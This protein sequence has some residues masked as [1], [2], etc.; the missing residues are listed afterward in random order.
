MMI[1]ALLMVPLRERH[2]SAGNFW[3]YS[4]TEEKLWFRASFVSGGS[5]LPERGL[6]NNSGWEGEKKNKTEMLMSASSW[7]F[8]H[9]TDQTQRKQN[10]HCL[11][12][13]VWIQSLCSVRAAGDSHCVVLQIERQRKGRGEKYLIV[14]G[15]CS[16]FFF[17]IVFCSGS[18]TY[19]LITCCP[20]RLSGQR[21]PM[22]SVAL[23]TQPCVRLPVTPL[24]GIKSICHLQFMVCSSHVPL[25]E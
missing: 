11:I 7:L 24:L 19:S 15:S 20:W 18:K 12:L 21:G 25:Y 13:A 16:M 3:Q 2:P 10:L 4:P 23:T 8:W 6:R 17:F 1:T 14:R 9:Q 22:S 5:V